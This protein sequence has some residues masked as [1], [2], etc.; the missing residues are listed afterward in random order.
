[1]PRVANVRILANSATRAAS[2]MRI[3]E[4]PYSVPH[5]RLCEVQRL[6]L[7]PWAAKGVRPFGPSG[8]EDQLLAHL[9]TQRP[10][11][12]TGI[13]LDRLVQFIAVFASIR[14]Y[15]DIS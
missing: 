2:P 9:G 1:M 10:A 11:F 7:A 13:Y 5:Y 12:R 8:A 15:P 14:W 3:Y 6:F 4:K